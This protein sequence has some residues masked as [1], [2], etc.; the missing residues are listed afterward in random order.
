MT[1]PTTIRFSQFNASLNRNNEGALVQDLSTPNNAQAKAVAEIIQR[2]SPD[3][4][5]INE[6]DYVSADP[7]APVKLFQQNYLSLSQNG[8]NPVDYPY[9]YIAP[10][11]TGI[12]SGF[13]LNND[14]RTVTTPGAAGYGDDAFGFGNFPGQ[15]GMLL[16]SKYPIDTDNIRTFQNFLWKDIP[17]SLLPTVSLPGSGTPWYSAEEQAALPL[18]S[19][20]HWDVPIVVNGQTIHALVSHPT[21]PVFDGAEDRNGKR[22]ADEIRFWADYVS[23][24]EGD[25]IYDDQGGSGGLQFGSS[26]V[27]MGDQNADPQDGDSFGK[28]ISQLLQN[29]NINT[30]FIPT[31]AGAVQQSDLQKGANLTHKSNPAFDTAD[32]ADTTPGNVR[33]DYVLPSNDLEITDSQVFWPLDTDPLF[34]L[35]GVFNPALPGGYPSSDHKLV[36]VDLQLGADRPGKTVVSAD[37]AGQQIFPTNTTQT[38]NGITTQIGGLSGLTYDAA[39]DRYYVVADDRGDRTIAG[40]GTTPPP[41]DN[42]PPRFYTVEIKLDANGAPSTTFTGVTLLRDSEGKTFAPLRLDPEDIVLTQKGTVFISSE[43][44]ANIAAGRIT[45][46]FV[47]EFDPMT[48]QQLRSLLVPQKFLPVVQD[49]NGNGRTDAGD[50]QTAGIR[51]NLAFESLTITPDQKFLY[52]ATE[53]ALFQDGSIATVTSGSPSRI[54]QYNL[55]TGQPEKEYLYNVDPVAKASIPETAFNT[56]GL[57]DL[58]AI[59]DRGTFLSVE[60]S[61]STGVP[62]TGNTIKIYEISLQ[63]ATDI[64]AIESLSSLS[65]EQ[66]ANL[67]PAQKRLV[68]NLDDLNLPTGTD[69]IEGIEFGPKLADGRQ[70]IVLVSDNNFSGTQF[71]QILTLSANLVTTVAPTVETSPERL[72]DPNVPFSQRADSDDPAI[73]LNTANADDSLVLTTLK[74]GGI[75]VH[76]LAGNTLQTVN[77]GNIRYNNVDLLYGF[78]LGGQSVDIAVASDRNNDKLVIFKVTASPVN[79]KYLEDITDSSIGTLFQAAPFDPPYSDSTRSAYGL[80]TYNS[81]V[82]GD[83]Y[84]FASRRQTGDVAQYKLIDAGNGKIGATRVRQFTIPVPASAPAD[85]EAQTEGMVTD[86]EL[87]YL[88]IGQEDVGIWKFQAEPTGSN[89]GTLIEPVKA[90]GGQYIANDVEGLTI[91]YSANGTGYLLA[92]SQGDNTFAVFSR[93]GSNEYIGQFA[94]GSSGTIDSVQESDGAEVINVPLGSNFPF[95]LFV[96]QDG[97]NDPARI[98]ED[99]NISNNFKYVPWENIAAPLGLTIDTT[100]TLQTSTQHGG[101][102]NDVLAGTEANDRLLGNDGDDVLIGYGGND[103]LIGGS[104][105]DGLDGGS[106]SDTLRGNQGNDYLQGRNGADLFVFAVGDGTDIVAD[107]SLSEGDRIGLSGGLTFGQLILTQQG[108]NTLIQAGT[109]ALAVLNNVQASTLTSAAFTAVA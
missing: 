70:S 92:S 23:P 55:V 50:T 100:N 95:G 108:S 10:S 19:K 37:F 82:T 34:R 101:S 5:L 106:G 107:F 77:P 98:V 28:A 13:D 97:S 59:D 38:L 57:V 104:G 74:N 17:G 75:E 6:F 69:N 4:L 58:L 26:F 91:Y 65:A 7:L 47:N 21:P 60:R 16:L 102:G 80:A 42:T 103:L 31:S 29:P 30:N 40:S 86:R 93:E 49:T 33:A 88:Y 45:N 73:Y 20:S 11:N 27:I 1:E 61:F 66:L 9:A 63:G 48:G 2:T 15:F 51:N 94:V 22:N 78:N 85:T 79:G 44:E 72:N 14:G 52:T 64:S 41:A 62:G 87:G 109:E 32:F 90:L 46:P 3:V 12:A 96:T 105:S 43:G 84:V 8:A 67:Q 35:V 36:W 76:D 24:G 54:I 83:A 71:T 68:L 39:N 53:N 25:Y 81:P 99:E 89:T 18:S 56:N